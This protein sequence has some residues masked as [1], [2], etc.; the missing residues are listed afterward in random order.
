MNDLKNISNRINGAVCHKCGGPAPH[1]KCPKCGIE[2][3][4]FDPN[5]WRNC[6][7]EAKMQAKCEKCNQ[8]EDNCTCVT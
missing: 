6:R 2:S 3:E 8:A 7:F 1:W 4:T 5:H